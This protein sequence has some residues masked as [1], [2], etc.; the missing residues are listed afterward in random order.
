M[1]HGVFTR[2]AAC[3][4][5]PEKLALYLLEMGAFCEASRS[6]GSIAQELRSRGWRKSAD[7]VDAIFTSEARHGEDYAQMAKL[8]LREEAH[9]V[10]PFS[11]FWAENAGFATSRETRNVCS[12]FWLRQH[13]EHALYSLGVL[14]VVEMA[15]HRQIIPGQVAAFIDS[16]FYGLTLSEVT[17][18]NVHA[19]EHGAEH[20]HEQAVIDLLASLGS[21]NPRDWSE[22]NRGSREFLT[23]LNGFYNRLE[24][25]ITQ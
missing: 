18:L 22:I 6:G 10:T 19:G 21:V 4:M 14:L 12:Q 23:A 13:R 15:A 16:G 9:L 17:Y 7:M 11:N 25:C 1:R 24:A 20:A 8:L 2:L 3:K 5:P